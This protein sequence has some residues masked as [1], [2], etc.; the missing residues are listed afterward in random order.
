MSL[1]SNFFGAETKALIRPCLR[2]NAGHRP[3]AA[4]RENRHPALAACG[5]KKPPP[6]RSPAEIA[7]KPGGRGCSLL[8]VDATL[9]RFAT[10]QNPIAG[11]SSTAIAGHSFECPFLERNFPPLADHPKRKRAI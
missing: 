11:R 8:S 6:C 9:C 2:S 4:A 7:M 10:A 3:C 1:P 5:Q